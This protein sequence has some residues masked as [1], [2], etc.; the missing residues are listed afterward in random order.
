M[1]EL[2]LPE[3][4]IALNQLLYADIYRYLVNMRKVVDDEQSY[5]LL[6]SALST[7]I[8]ILLAQTSD[9][10]RERYGKICKSIIDQ[11]C[12]THIKIS[13]ESNYGQIGHA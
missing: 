5:H 10:N 8:G 6:L 9:N 7:N 12:N 11:S 3:L 13:D 2:S 1:D 4:Q